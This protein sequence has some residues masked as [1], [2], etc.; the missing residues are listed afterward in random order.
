MSEP[1]S[2][3]WTVRE[4][5]ETGEEERVHV[6]KWK[7]WTQDEQ[8]PRLNVERLSWIIP[9]TLVNHAWAQHYYPLSKPRS[10]GPGGEEEGGRGKKGARWTAS[11]SSPDTSLKSCSAWSWPEPA[12]STRRF[13]WLLGV[14][15]DGGNLLDFL[16]WS[17]EKNG[18]VKVIS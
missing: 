18:C 5:T 15:G 6:K 10:R 16:S 14:N 1:D 3:E 7:I 4:E 12:A 17:F 11:S 2:D 8:E 9:S 13:S